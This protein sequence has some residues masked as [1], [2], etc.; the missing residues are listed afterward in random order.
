MTDSRKI[1]VLVCIALVLVVLYLG[2]G[3]NA[4]NWD[5][6]LSRRI[7]KIAAITATSGAA[8]ASTI[9]FQ[10]VTNNRILTPSIMGLDALYLLIQTSLLF[11]V[12]SNSPLVLNQNWNFLIVM[13]VMIFFALLLYRIVYT[14]ADLDIHLLLLVGLIL[15]TL[16]QS[17]TSLLQMVM[18]PNEFSIV[19]NR[20]FA[21]FNNVNTSVLTLSLVM[22]GG[23]LL[24]VSRYF[25]ILDVMALGREHAINLGVAYGQVVQNM[26]MVVA[27]LVSISTAMVG[28]IMFLGLLA[29]NLAR[30]LLASYKH[31]CLIG[32]AM[33]LSVISLVGG[34]LLVE[35][36]LNFAAPLSVLIN[37]I[38]GL[39]FIYLLWKENL[40]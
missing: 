1:T 15:G 8:A 16:F 37:L 20:M 6:A 25:A 4:R 35:R 34:Q 17:S 9:V 3:L 7:P 11:F 33:L 19:Q 38:G 28:P 10:T 14:K 13:G 12:G 26:L 36:V 23:A 24:Y 27:I 18:D 40:A 5:Y 39:Y 31:S 30:E 22:L 32:A 2:L 21:S 29:A